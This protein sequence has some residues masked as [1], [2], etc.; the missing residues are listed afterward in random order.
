DGAVGS[1]GSLLVDSAGNLYGVTELGGAHMAGTVFE[2]SPSGRRW[3]FKTLYAFRGQPDAGSPYG[4]LV[5]DGAGNLY[6]TTYYG[7]TS[8][9][10]AVYK[11]TLNARGNYRENVLY[12]FKG[13]SDGSASTST[14]VFG[15]PGILYGTTSSG[16]NS[17]DCGTVFLV[18][19]KSG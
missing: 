4:G 5:A 18:H 1:L 11:L 8:G 12:S 19:A 13:G 7:G 16:G 6:G 3:N 15:K 17:C 2:L 14:L 9:L 10:G